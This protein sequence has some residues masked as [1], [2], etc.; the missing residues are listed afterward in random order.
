MES[1]T[2]VLEQ[3]LE[4]R[5]KAAIEA[6]TVLIDEFELDGISYCFKGWPQVQQDGSYSVLW[7]RFAD[8]EK[9]H[10]GQQGVYGYHDDTDFDDH[11]YCSV[12][13]TRN[14][15]YYWQSLEKHRKSEMLKYSVTDWTPEDE[16]WNVSV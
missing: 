8:G 1:R 2:D 15:A 11:D 6:S 12:C 16:F 7:V 13:Y 10:G 9:S 3:T 4:D 14:E 5:I